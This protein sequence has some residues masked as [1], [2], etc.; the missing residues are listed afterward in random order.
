MG[1]FFNS[2]ASFESLLVLSEDMRTLPAVVII[3]VVNCCVCGEI[4]HEPG[5]L[6]TLK[7]LVLHNS[8]AVCMSARVGVGVCVWVCSGQSPLQ[9]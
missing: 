7:S 1:K 6:A 3:S 8:S 5:F 9:P 4:P 2:C